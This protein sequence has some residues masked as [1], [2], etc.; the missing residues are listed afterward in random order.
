MVRKYGS[1]TIRKHLASRREFLKIGGLLI[2][3]GM[4][5]PRF[6]EAQTGSTFAYYISPTGS[7]ANA[8]TLAS[9]WAISSLSPYSGS[10]NYSKIGGKR[11]GL[12]PG[13][14]GVGKF[15]VD[16]WNSQGTDGIALDIPGGSSS[17]PTYIASCN[18]QGTYSRGTATIQ[19][20]DNGSF[21]GG[22]AVAVSMIG[23]TSARGGWVTLDGL[24][25]TGASV[26]CV[27]F[28]DIAGNNTSNSGYVIQNCEIT[29]NNCQS[30]PVASGKNVACISIMSAIGAVVTNNYLHD[31]MGWTDGQHFSAIYHWG[32]GSGTGG[33]QITYNTF[34]NSGGI[35]LKEN[36][37]WDMQVAYNYIDMT[38]VTPGG[39]LTNVAPIWGGC[40][41][42]SSSVMPGGNGTLAK[43]H[44]NV[45]IAYAGNSN[46]SPAE[47]GGTWLNLWFGNG[48][49]YWSYPVDVYN[50][51]CVATSALNGS[52]VNISSGSAS[53]RGLVSFYNNLFWD[54][55]YNAVGQYGW[56]FT[57]KNAFTVCDYN[58]YGTHQ[59]NSNWANFS[60]NGSQGLG[61]IAA[62]AS[63]FA[64]W[65]AMTGGDAHSTTN[66]TNPFTNSGSLAQQY[67]VQSGSPA[68]QAGRIGGTA[69][70]G[71]CNVG[72]WDGTVTQIGCNL[73]A[74]AS[75]P[76]S[77]PAPQAPTLKLVPG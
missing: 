45:L 37:Q 12:L 16:A 41:D 56:F 24:K 7:D 71:A 42:G 17:S 6:L 34:V 66:S 57:N 5:F 4:G 36:T 48:Q 68:Y 44:H 49:G 50:N 58:I 14:Y 61:T 72:A 28:G 11:V 10:A 21:G 8:G 39:Q 70:G 52:G 25:L 55:G 29:G 1:N 67:Q 73:S 74:S 62:T 19:G 40:E 23:S 77:N 43:F 60:A 46:I 2:P 75:P 13:T 9:P 33:T 30:A 63:N 51:T 26:W 47:L 35:Q 20:N 38:T 53:T 3:I 69:S 59:G 15:M 54:A 64:N 76:P 27:T 32:L 65:Q 18:A 22:N 31:N